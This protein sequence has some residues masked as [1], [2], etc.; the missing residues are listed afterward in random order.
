MAVPESTVNTVELNK[1]QH[2]LL[3]EQSATLR[4]ALK[5]TF[6]AKGFELSVVSDYK[7]GLSAIQAFIAGSRWFSGIVMGWPADTHVY[8]D[9]ILVTLDDSH[10]KGLPVLLLSEEGDPA[11]LDWIT[12]RQGTALLP[13]SDYAECTAAMEQLIASLD[14]DDH[15]YLNEGID[16]AIR[17]L[18]VDDSPSVRHS[19]RSLLREHSYDVDSASCVAEALKLIEENQYDIAIIDY[20]MPENNGDVLVRQL[21]ENPQTRNIAIA[22]ITGTYSDQV[23]K[24]CLDAGAVECMFK[25]EAKELFL[26]RVRS[27]TRSILDRRS[28]DNERRRLQRILASVGDGVYGVDKRGVIEFINPA[29]RRILGYKEND[30][31]VGKLAHSLFHF[32]TEDGAKTKVQECHLS[33]CYAKGSQL[34]EW[35]TVFWHREGYQVSVECTVYPM[36][37]EEEHAGVVVAFRDIS[38]R[39]HLEEELRWQATH[40]SLT[41]LL[42][43]K[44]F[45][46][47]I[48][49]EVIRLRRSASYSALLLIDLDRFKYINDTAGHI[50]GDHLLTEVGRRL[51]TRLRS[52]DTLARIGGDEYAIILR[53]I[54]SDK[55]E[56][57]M[58]AEGFRYAL[59]DEKF[60]YDGKAY[61]VTATMGVAVMHKG[62]ASLEEIMTN[63]DIACHIAK[64]KGRNQTHI[65]SGDYD[66]QAAMNLELG[67][68]SRLRDALKNNLF[69][70]NFQ[71]ILPFNV[72]SNKKIV[73]TDIWPEYIKSDVESVLFYEVLLRLK[74]QGDEPIVPGAF[75]PTAER[76]DIMLDIDRWVIDN[77]FKSLSEAEQQQ[78][79]IRL[80]INLSAQTLADNNTAAYIK[81]RAAVHGINPKNI[82]FEITETQAVTN[83]EATKALIH[84]LKGL[85]C[86]FALDDFGSGFC[87]FGQLKHLDVAY[88]KIDGLFTQGVVS[89]PIDRAVIQAITQMA[90]SLGRYT[91]VEY[92]DSPAII[93]A[94]EN[95][96]VDYVQGYHISKPM[97]A[98]LLK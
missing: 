33:R 46:E 70:L 7:E 73:Q 61:D 37:S 25:S 26:A 38:E 96:G 92:V 15:N 36:E 41:K 47:Q 17:I 86:Q 71:P 93:Q 91:V 5:K 3:I 44:Y 87:S 24:E 21:K 83:I 78:R 16:H 76:F 65:F 55:E 45:E 63:A 52:S 4:H 19:F 79:Q 29:A 64:S 74:D 49:E 40:D 39:K 57:F 30:D 80:S 75:L 11:K 85:G 84:E 34:N 28:I 59:N 97:Q 68:S 94:L 6:A 72:L 8:A 43:R 54:S 90:R 56:I 89:D 60:F 9:E 13:W 48:N 35:Q 98:L 69:T 81:E 51:Q 50:A 1:N 67:W 62:T 66:S 32:A 22:I 10:L 53:N 12:N 20:F 42:N 58:I 95:S 27:L 18:F 82:L 77:A 2:Y 88:I 23:I 14:Y 31:I